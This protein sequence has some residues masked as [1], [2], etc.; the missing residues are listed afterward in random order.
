MVIVASDFIHLFPLSHDDELRI[1]T[2]KGSF[3]ANVQWLDP[4][5]LTLF[6]LFLS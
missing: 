4:V 3:M 1:M 5:I 6:M 2:T